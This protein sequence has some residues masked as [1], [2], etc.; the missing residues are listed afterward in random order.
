MNN[1]ARVADS[2]IGWGTSVGQW[3]RIENKS[4]VGED[5]HVKVLHSGHIFMP[6]RLLDVP[7]TPKLSRTR[8]PWKQG[9]SLMFLGVQDEVF[10]NGT[11]VLPH[12]DIKESNLDPGTIIM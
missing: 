2:I 12:K 8:N 7:A 1:Y 4:V 11:I 5:V 9:H 3:S 6:L 10:M